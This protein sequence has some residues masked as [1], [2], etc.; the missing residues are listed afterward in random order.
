MHFIRIFVGEDRCVVHVSGRT[1]TF[2]ADAGAVTYLLKD[3]PGVKM[4]ETIRQVARASGPSLR[5]SPSS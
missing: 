1:K 2:L 5:R 3:T 4:I